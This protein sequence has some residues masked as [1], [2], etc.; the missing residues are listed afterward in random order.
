MYIHGVFLEGAAWE[1]GNPGQTGYLIDQKLKE[2]HP[3]LPIINVI[4]MKV[5][6]ISTV[7]QYIC[8]VY[9]TSARGM[10]FVF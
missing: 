4:A 10:T 2:L 1:L 3:R 5:S 9:T 7:G 6:E 8:P